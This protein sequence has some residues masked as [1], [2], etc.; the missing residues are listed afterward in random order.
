MKNGN[1]D[2]LPIRYVEY[3]GIDKTKWDACI[4]NA[5]NGLIYAYSFYLDVM[6]KH[7]DALVMNDYEAVMPL[8]WNKKYGIYYL[9]QPFLCA[10]LGLFG[11]QLTR[12]MLLDFLNKIPKHFK[13][14]DIYLNTANSFQFEGYN[15]Y[16]R[17]NYILPVQKN[18]NELFNDFRS[19]YR[20]LI[21]KATDKLTIKQNIN[22]P[23]IIKL[24]KSK[25]EKISSVKKIDLQNFEQL[26]KA[27]YA[28]N[29]AINYG[30]YLKDELL[31]SG[32]FLFSHNRAY[33]IL[34]G[35]KDKGRALGA[36]HLVIDAFIRHCAGKNIILDFEGS[37]VPG[38][39]FFFKGFGAQIEEYPGLKYTALPSI[40]KKLKN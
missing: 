37:N 21:K 3:S 10:S 29:K 1:F 40:F 24:A 27:L 22:I 6:A 15:L 16:K 12:D 31:A 14:W 17:V 38:I 19:S 30:V 35:N 36:S 32:I 4:E 23:D 9:Y 25:L 20:Q 2:T 5:S 33:Y 39:S 28:K 7:W 26:Y 13:Y 18:Y 8:T 34:A 11:N